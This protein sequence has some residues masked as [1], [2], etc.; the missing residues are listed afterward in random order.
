MTRF[1]MLFLG[2]AAAAPAALAQQAPAAGA[3]PAVTATTPAPAQTPAT[4]IVSP[5]PATP[6]VDKWS[7]T[8]YGFAELDTIYDTRQGIGEV[9]GN[10]VLPHA[11]SYAGYSDRTQFSIRNSRVGFR[12][13]SPEFRRMRASGLVEMDFFGS[14]PNSAGG[15]S[16][17]GQFNSAPLRV[18]HAMG[19]LETPYVDIL[20]G[21][22]WELF[23]WQPYFHPNTV[24]VQGV[25]GE[26]YSRTAQLRLSRTFRTDP[27]NVDVAVA[28]VRPPQRDA[29]LPD[30][31]AGVRVAFNGLKGARTAG[32]T[33]SSIDPASIGVSGTVRKFALETPVAGGT[34]DPRVQSTATGWGVSFDGILPVIPATVDD[35]SNAITLTGSYV[36]GSG[37]QDLYSGFSNG[38]G[39]LPLSGQLAS[40]N[41]IDN[42]LAAFDASGKLQSIDVR[43]FI[44][45]AQY[46]LPIDRGAVWVAG[47]YSQVHSDNADLNAGAV[48]KGSSFLRSRWAD[49]CIFWDATPAVRFGA[50]YAWFENLLADRTLAHN[51]RYQL[52]VFYIF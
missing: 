10:P 7:A 9:P 29:G 42:G 8:L 5:K 32:S 2:V 1:S 31:Q 12:F 36:R 24:E 44:I 23:G 30:G 14:Q 46:Y 17:A 18:R 11:G 37:I 40:S 48:A 45:G 16:E 19:K 15:N 34:P 41:A 21:Q 27:V 35:R 3:G 13:S 22:Y 39:A 52:S 47:N 50:E 43:S 33:G 25:P 28:A 51:Q 49:A 4:A 20:A 6:V 26:V 38:G